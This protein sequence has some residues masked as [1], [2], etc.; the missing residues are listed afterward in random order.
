MTV[1]QHLH[2]NPGLPYLN[3]SRSMDIMR[4]V[5]SATAGARRLDVVNP[6]T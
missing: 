1:D 4:L 2:N 6:Q 3:D 5:D